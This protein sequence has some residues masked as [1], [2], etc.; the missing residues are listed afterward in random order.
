MKCI[1]E[2]KKVWRAAG[3]K[4]GGFKN[5]GHI[6]FK[7]PINNP[8]GNGYQTFGYMTWELNTDV[9]FKDINLRVI[10]T[11]REMNKS[12]IEGEGN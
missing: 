2:M 4:K 11:Y 8:S 7:M 3:S 12:H 6:R 10:T 5:F 9:S 1:M